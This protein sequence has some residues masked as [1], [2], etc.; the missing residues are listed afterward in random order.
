MKRVFVA[1]FLAWAMGVTPG[2]ADDAVVP[3]S[4][5]STDQPSATSGPS[6]A[7]Q[8]P[9]ATVTADPADVVE[10]SG[11][12]GEMTVVYAVQDGDSLR[13][14]SDTATSTSDA[15]A[16]VDQVQDRPDV[17]AVEVDTTRRLTGL[18]ASQS[19]PG[20]TSTIRRESRAAA[21]PSADP[22]RSQ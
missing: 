9:A 19:R 7:W 11:E 5:P 17:V 12:T 18:P 1:V 22:S 2:A 15:I 10:Q 6:T 13:V 16:T 14:V 20:V 3:T 8:E 4:T 21:I